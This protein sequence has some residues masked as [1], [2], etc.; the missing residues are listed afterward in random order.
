VAVLEPE[1]GRLLTE[2]REANMG[3]LSL[4]VFANTVIKG[5]KEKLTA[6]MEKIDYLIVM[7]YDFHSSGSTYAGA[8]APM[9]SESGER[10]IMEITERINGYDLDKKKII[11]AYP[12]YGYEWRTET[13]E[14]G[15]AVKSYVQMWSYRRTKDAESTKSFGEPKWDEIA[16]G[17]WLTYLK[18]E[19]VTWKEKVKVGKVW[20]T[21]TRSKVVEVPR[22]IYYENEKSLG[23]K[24]DL[25]EQLRLGGVGFWALG[26]E[27]QD[28][29]IWER[30]ARL[31]K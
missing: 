5:E 13:S 15:S 9:R 29:V 18:E 10:N 8:V 3:E 4:D 22:Q 17:P 26:Y 28:K 23:I 31:E 24:L 19:T 30:V 27:G 6:L 16:G 7:A 20:K 14:L 1:F 21:V 12:L 2:M 25:V 11:M